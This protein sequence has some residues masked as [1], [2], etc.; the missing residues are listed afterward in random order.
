M[1]VVVS[2]QRLPDWGAVGGGWLVASGQWQVV[3]VL[4]YVVVGCVVVGRTK[5]AG[6]QS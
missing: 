6:K 2:G 5:V 4:I 3:L 1:V